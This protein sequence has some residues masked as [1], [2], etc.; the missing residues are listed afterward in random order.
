MTH[1]LLNARS[2]LNSVLNMLSTSSVMRIVLLCLVAMGL[3]A[4]SH[5]QGLGPG[6]RYTFA[7]V[8]GYLYESDNAALRSEATFGG[9]LGIGFGRYLQVS[10]EYILGNDL[11]TNLGEFESLAGLSER[12]V[13]L[14]R[15]GGRLRLNLSGSG[16]IPYL[17]AG[18]GI[19][20]FNPASVDKTESIYATVGGGFTFRLAQRYRVS[21]GGELLSYRYDPV[22]T[23]VGQ[24]IGVDIGERTVY[25]PSVRASVEL[26]LGGRSLEEQTAVDEAFRE[27]FS[28]GLSS[29]R[30][31]VDPFYGRLQFNDALGFP[32]DQNLFGVNAGFDLG[33]YVGLRGF[34]W[35]GTTGDEAFD[36]LSTTTEDIQLYGSELKLR[37]RPKRSSTVAPYGL[38]GGGYLDAMSG[39]EDNIPDGATPPEDR[40][41]ATG[42]VGLEV[43]LTRS[44]LLVGDVRSLLMSGL[45]VDEVS[46]PSEVY[47][48]LMYSI[49]VEFN[50]GG[51]KR[52]RSR[53]APAG[54]DDPA[55]SPREAALIARIDSLEQSIA[56]M[57][58]QQA[59]PADT[60]VVMETPSAS[61][62]PS[63]P[64]DSVTTVAVQP[65]E[66]EAQ[67][68]RASNLSG[69]TIMLPVPEVGEIYVRFGDLPAGTA[70]PQSGATADAIS[71]LQQ[72][73]TG[74]G[75]SDLTVEQ[76][77]Q[78]VRSAVQ[79][80][81]QQVQADTTGALLT[82]QQVERT[83]RQTLRE[84]VGAE[85]EANLTAQAEMERLEEQIEA[86]RNQIRRQGN[87]PVR[88]PE[89]RVVSG[90][91]QVVGDEQPFYR[92]F[93]GQPLQGFF[94]VVSARGG[95]G[96]TQVLAG[97][98][99][100]YRQRGASRF[101][102]LPEVMLGFGNGATSISILG[103]VSYT[104]FRAL[105]E[106]NTGLPLEPYVGLG[107]GIAS[108]EGL[109][110]EFVGNVML[111]TDYRLDNGNIFFVE[112]STLDVFDYNRFSFGYRIRF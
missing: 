46:T 86:L 3:A 18:T 76:I 50:L 45:Q 53:Q 106:R 87:Q 102:I 31:T 85:G 68:I 112:Y 82:Q 110:L 24:D 39:Y 57:E 29:I 94:P 4:S 70:V 73:Q 26:F 20:E 96:P 15:Y 72:G 42:G 64:P 5:A 40:F 78:I 8:G 109:D 43:P 44:V 52:D 98:R 107:L 61:S 2:L 11:T 13:D 37:L 108:P 74:G 27:Q 35:R 103:N 77:Q 99:G 16:Y 14:R 30:L 104:L 17:S 60:S 49:G 32:K 56:M 63:A 88:E 71:Q 83:V 6:I 55:V 95:D 75:A 28:G 25:S 36:D 92:S 80:Q 47:G 59:P 51:G 23:F 58:Q 65:S 48:S 10:G 67:V 111:G 34:Y 38:I 12:S 93:L 91:T 9:E 66:G 41:F 7:P 62:A 89:T 84:Y 97:V 101:R 33:P 100:D 69:Q 19:L 21:L 22:S 90:G 54:V 105:T 1:S 81:M 79:T